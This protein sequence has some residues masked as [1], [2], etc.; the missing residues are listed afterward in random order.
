MFIKEAGI[1]TLGPYSPGGPAVHKGL[2][3]KGRQTHQFLMHPQGCHRF[4]KFGQRHRVDRVA[5]WRKWNIIQST[6]ELNMKSCEKL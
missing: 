4:S 6:N 2:N 5:V 1:S 3:G